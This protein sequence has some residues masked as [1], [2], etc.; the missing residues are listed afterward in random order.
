MAKI[1][2]EN[3][4]ICKKVHLI[5][6]TDG[7][8]EQESINLSDEILKDNNIIFGYV[9]YY[10]I[11]SGVNYKVGVPY[12][13]G[14]PNQTIRVSSIGERTVEKCLTQEDLNALENINNIKTFDE[15]LENVQKISKGLIAKL[16]GKE[17]T[18]IQL[19]DQ[20]KNM[21]KRIDLDLNMD[22]KCKEKL[23]NYYNKLKQMVTGG[24]KDAYTLDSI[25]GFSF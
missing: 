4:T 18:D 13:R 5:L 23:E 24:L 17:D 14:C 11:G 6:V 7:E 16:S 15:F 10:L 9:S 20:L 25:S 19:L 8:V 1:A 3:R 12:S 21:K 22:E 2:L